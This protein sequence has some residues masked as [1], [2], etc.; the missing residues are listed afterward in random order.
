M[1]MSNNPAKYE[2]LI[3]QY[4]RS[5]RLDMSGK[6]TRPISGHLDLTSLVKDLLYGFRGKFSFATQR[7]V[8][9]ELHLARSDSQSQFRI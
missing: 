9:S 6:R 4:L 8:P 1:K 5:I 2:V 3:K 7:V